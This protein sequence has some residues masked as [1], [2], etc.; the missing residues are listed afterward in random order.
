MD[1]ITHGSPAFRL[2]AVDLYRDIHKGI[3]QELFGLVEAAGSAD[4]NRPDERIELRGH[5]AAVAA[6][7]AS[8]AH[9]EDD[10]ILPT[11]ERELPD[12]AERIERD[13]ADLD[14][15]F[16]LIDE[17][18]EAFVSST[19]DR[20]AG[21]RLYLDIARFVSDY[22]I[23]IDVEERDLMPRL[24]DA[25]GVDAVIDMHARIVAAIPPDEMIRTMSF[26]LPAMNLDDRA[27]ML[28]AMREE[29]P[30]EAFAGVVDLARSVLRP[31]AF[32]ALSERLGL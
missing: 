26:M 15:R 6:M 8:H 28:G 13:H 25:V 16:G 10:A 18:S 11:L 9:H 4:V 3:R 2:V 23:H 24:E 20:L 17:Q 5:I 12:L 27:D 22:L 19:A 1:M 32:T 7:L 21:Q 30:A 31:G 14:H 29:A